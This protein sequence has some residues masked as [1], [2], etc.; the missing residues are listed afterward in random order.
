M[1]L[2][3]NQVLVPTAVDGAEL[4]V[5]EDMTGLWVKFGHLSILAQVFVGSPEDG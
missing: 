5:Y 1:S 3:K 2:G 4:A